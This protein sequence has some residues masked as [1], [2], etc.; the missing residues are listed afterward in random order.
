M[1]IGIDARPLSNKTPA[2]IGNYLNEVLKRLPDLLPD[3]DFYLY[4]NHEVSSDF[5]Y[6]DKIH[7]RIIPSKVGTL[8]LRYKLPKILKKDGMDIFWGTN[9]LL[10]GKAKGIKYILTVHDVNLIINRKWGSNINYLLHKLYLQDS[11]KTAETIITVSNSTSSL[12]SV[13]A[14]LIT[15]G[16]LIATTKSQ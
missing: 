5:C 8:W 1:K 3:A 13:F 9:Q 10:P 16:L 4:S 15:I 14:L 12:S 7:L 2:G 6:S 11:L